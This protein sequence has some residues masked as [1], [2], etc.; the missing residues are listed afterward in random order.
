MRI[1]RAISHSIPS[2]L[3]FEIGN[4]TEIQNKIP[5]IRMRA[6]Q[7]QTVFKFSCKISQQTYE[8]HHR[9]YLCTD[10][11]TST[12]VQ[13]VPN[14]R[15][16]PF[17]LQCICI[18]TFR[19]ARN[20]SLVFSFIAFF[21]PSRDVNQCCKAIIFHIKCVFVILALLLPL[22]LLLPSPLCHCYLW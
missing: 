3:P 17:Q 9:L 18:R 6:Q 5:T 12:S 13:M 1:F 14:I 2:C 8:I 10:M 19:D 7:K 16:N 20:I 4:R 21:L 22:Q 11:T 15:A